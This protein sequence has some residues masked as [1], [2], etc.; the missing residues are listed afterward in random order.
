MAEI[1]S[2]EE[3]LDSIDKKCKEDDDFNSFFKFCIGI[4]LIEE[5]ERQQSVRVK[6]IVVCVI[7]NICYYANL[8]FFIFG[9]AGAL[10]IPNYILKIMLCMIPTLL[11][12][13]W[14]CHKTL[15]THYTI[16]H[17]HRRTPIGAYT[18]IH[19]MIDNAVYKE[20]IELKN[21]ELVNNGEEP[22][23]KKQFLKNIKIQHISFME[24]GT[25]LLIY[26]SDENKFSWP[27]ICVHADFDGDIISVS[28]TNDEPVT[29]N[30]TSLAN[31]N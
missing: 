2:V 24:C 13:D 21:Q 23:S 9:L 11:T 14:V 12:I 16:L 18:S 15:K 28:L 6:T 25:E 4:R 1:K 8:V 7:L 19:K 5:L 17:S 26:C 22:L 3:V 10:P 20:L 29:T 30:A 27:G 31:I